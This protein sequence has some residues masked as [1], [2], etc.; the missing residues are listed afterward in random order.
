MGSDVHHLQN[1]FIELFKRDYP[2]LEK[3]MDNLQFI[4]IKNI[5]SVIKGSEERLLMEMTGALTRP[6]KQ[7]LQIKLRQ[8]IEAE[9]KKF[10][11]KVTPMTDKMKELNQRLEE[12]LKDIHNPQNNI[13]YM[14]KYFS[15]AN[16]LA[17]FIR[18][19]HIGGLA[20]QVS[21]TV[22]LTGNIT[23]VFGRIRYVLDRDSL[24]EDRAVPKILW[25]EFQKLQKYMEEI[26]KMQNR[27]AIREEKAKLQQLLQELIRLT[28]EL[29]AIEQ[30]ASICSK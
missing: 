16:E 1:E 2:K 11:D 25:E 20:A 13:S 19:Y 17:C 26:K 3:C 14:S 6:S 30:L 7:S 29:T 15:T 27:L 5:V 23:D 12:I 10:Q 28:V 24:A 9:I 8:D 18:K 22:A 21:K 4:F